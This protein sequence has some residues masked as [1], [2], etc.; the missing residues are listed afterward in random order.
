MK[1]ICSNDL[2]AAM[3]AMTEAMSITHVFDDCIARRGGGPVMYALEVKEHL[4]L[5]W[6]DED[7][8][9]VVVSPI[10][11]WEANNLL[12]ALDE[13]LTVLTLRQISGKAFENKILSQIA[14]C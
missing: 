3:T 12:E 11:L 8:D 9:V 10:G 2:A 14:L 13:P 5:A 7:T 4:F 1:N 6:H